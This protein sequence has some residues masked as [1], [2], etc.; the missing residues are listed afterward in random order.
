M[1]SRIL[2]LKIRIVKYSLSGEMTYYL[3]KMNKEVKTKLD[4]QNGL[5]INTSI[6]YW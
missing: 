5:K 4:Q 1:R 6:T 3:K 2:Q